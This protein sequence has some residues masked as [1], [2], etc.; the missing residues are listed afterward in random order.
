MDWAP[1]YIALLRE[2]G[3]APLP[4]GLRGA[5]ALNAP[6]L[7]TRL[8][9][10]DLTLF[11]RADEPVS[12]SEDGSLVVLG[13]LYDSRGR[14]VRLE[15]T[16]GWAPASFPTMLAA[17]W[18]QYLAFQRHA[19]GHWA[20]LRDPGG[21]LVA[22]LVDGM[23]GLVADEL[24][25]WLVGALAVRVR[26]ELRLV[27]NALAMPTMTAHRSLLTNVTMLEAGASAG[28]ARGAWSAPILA[29]RALARAPDRDADP[30][31]IR[32][33]LFTVVR[34]LAGNRDAGLVELSG[35]LDSAIVLGA[36]RACAP[37]FP[38]IALNLATREGSGD[39]RAAARDAAARA[40][41]ELVEVA[42]RAED[43][44]FRH[45]M[46]GPQPAQRIAY[47]L[48]SIL[49]RSVAG[50]A[51][52]FG[53]DMILTGQG[54][55]ATFFQ[56]PAAQLAVDL[57]RADGIRAL[58]SE[59]AL[60][61]ARRTRVSLW[62]LH[63]LMLTDRWRRPVPER[64]PPSGVFLTA[65]ARAMVTRD[66]GDH[67]WL[68]RGGHL[69]PAKRLQLFALANCQWFNGPA[70]RRARAALIHPL[71]AQP[72]V[73]ACLAMPVP[74]LSHGTQDRALARALFADLLPPSILRRRAK[75]ETSAYYRRAIVH[76]LPFLRAHLL[77]GA[78]VA[79]G[80]LDR[81][82]LAAA[83]DEDALIRRQ[84][85]GGV[86]SLGS[87]EAWARYWGL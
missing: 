16:D 8:E 75:G 58:F 19:A 74:R 52:A 20:V 48:D 65:A 43:L 10:D 22:W 12:V 32:E 34:T 53:A 6:H 39:E 27:A 26:P 76:N 21:T 49:E 77:E 3:E 57:W 70:S 35:G 17:C 29:W 1:R 5:I 33:A 81:A 42:A 61:V 2:P 14:A 78:L 63:W 24:P 56:F 69:P 9:A 31:R 64:M 18:G 60:D 4:E 86:I 80:L 40:G 15:G 44:D 73:E 54:G 41:V 82:A 83:L 25:R 38:L 23:P 47:G 36:L 55:D 72:V 71:L 37:D 11:A 67:P 28:W 46:T 79:A 51:A 45:A 68:A 7:A 59:A 30:M 84:D 87:L 85:A 13:A 50:A 66:L 62:R